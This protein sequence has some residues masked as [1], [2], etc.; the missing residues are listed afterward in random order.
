MKIAMDKLARIFSKGLDIIETEQLGAST[1]HSM[2]V[3]AL[4]SEMCLRLGYD[5][6]TIS[7]LSIC[8]LFHDNALTEFNLSEEI[9]ALNAENV[10]RHCERG[11]TNVSKLPFKKD[12]SGYVLYHHEREGGAGPFGKKEGEYPFE[13]ALLAAADAVDVAFRFSRVAPEKLSAARDR[14]NA[15]AGRY[16]TRKAVDVLLDVLDVQMLESLRDENINKT[17]DSSLPDWEI[18]LTTENVIGIADFFTRVIDHKSIFTRKHTSQIAN[19]AWLMAGHY[20]YSPEEQAALYFAASLHD[21]GKIAT[22]T[23]VLEKP[24]KL[25]DEEFQIIKDHVRYTHDWLSEMPGFEL[26]RNWAADHHEKL[27][28]TGYPFGK[29][30]DELDK[31]ARMLACIDIYQAVCEERPYHAARSH[32]DTMPILQGMA[33][34]GFIDADIVRDMDEIMKPYSMRDIPSPVV[35]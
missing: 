3:A 12:V 18:E 1:H 28:G 24:G 5:E 11:Q 21:I 33:E 30:A 10:K 32:E 27:D 31:N 20:G 29:S 35:K 13:A 2:R 15:N 16:S 4:C 19:R 25:D 8:A 14:I 9:M 7:A 22:P 17:M 34:K 23:T 6:E 26:I